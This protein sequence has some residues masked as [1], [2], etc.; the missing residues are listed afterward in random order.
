M[1]AARRAVTAA[2]LGAAS[3]ALALGAAPADSP[4]VDPVVFDEV[5]GERGIDFVT[6]S[7]RSARRY[8]PETMVAGV[9]LFDYDDDGWLD[10]YAVNGAP[11]LTLE[12]NE[13]KYWNRL[14]RNKG[15]GQFVDVTEQAG[16]AGKGYDLGVVAA[17]Y[18]NDGDR[19]LFVAGLRRNTLYRNN[20]DG[21]FSDATDAAGLARP[22]PKYGTLWAIAG[23]FFDYDKDG[24]LDLIVSN[25]VVWD[26]ASDPVCG[27]PAAP[28][29]CRPDHYQGLPNSLF[30]NNGDGTFSDVSEKSGI[31]A[32]VGKG[33]GLGVADFDD[34]GWSDVFVANDTV[35]SFLFVNNKNGSFT[36][37]AFERAVALPDR[38]EPV[39]G[40]G[41]DARDVDNDGRPDV[42]LTALTAD[43]FPLFRNTGTTA[44]EDV[45]VRTGVGA[46]TRP[47]TGWGN[48]IVDLNNDGYKDLFAACA[49]VL[50]PSGTAGDRV[51][52]PN[53]LL[54]NSRNGRFVD[55]NATAGEEFKRRAVHRGAAFGDIDNDGRLDVAVTAVDGALELWRNVSPVRNHWLQLDVSGAKGNRDAM[56]ARVV[57]TTPSGTQ[58][59]LVNTAVGYGS[60]SDA[61]VHFGLGPD[62]RV[63]ELKVTWPTGQTQTLRNL[64]ADQLVRVPAPR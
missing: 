52:M 20:G 32:H 39:A 50:D 31:R 16:V 9:A 21:T 13:P 36:E 5:A 17:D 60:S 12:K 63:R 58:H 43:M 49:G 11:I 22:D 51:P 10:L 29:Y 61:R 44:F 8:Q 3:V 26:H 30:R 4:P 2:L 57:L 27:D 14:Y 53:L 7:S 45:T 34:D 41:V 54:L 1:H 23:A 37:S 46:L 47:W 15:K 42:F 56:G 64:P 33:M 55:G 18:D 19:D 62:T 59:N 38:G 25:Y 35:P 24:W 6:H 28:D 48:A 40:M